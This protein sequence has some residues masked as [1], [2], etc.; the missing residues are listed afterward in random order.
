[1]HE[2]PQQCWALLIRS[3][4]NFVVRSSRLSTG[5]LVIPMDSAGS[6]CIKKALGFSSPRFSGQGPR[7]PTFSASP[8]RVRHFQNRRSVAR[9]PDV[10]AGRFFTSW[11]APASA[12]M[13]TIETAQQG[14]PIPAGDTPLKTSYGNITK[15]EP[16]LTSGRQ[17]LQSTGGT[18]GTALRS[19]PPPP[20]PW[21]EFETCS[22][23]K[24]GC[25]GV[26]A[27]QP[28]G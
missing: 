23:A 11:R 3:A 20:G 4:N 27:K 24:P 26:A 19:T 7:P 10:I 17:L 18:G 14:L 22:A 9:I 15:V 12:L 16:K 21:R 28:W 13:L 2:V 6:S 25:R 5:S 1:M 8:D